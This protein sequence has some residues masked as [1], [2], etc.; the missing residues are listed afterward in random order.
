[1]VMPCK[2]EDGETSTG[3]SS[4]SNPAKSE[5][6][7][8]VVEVVYYLSW[9]GQLGHPH[10]VEVPMSCPPQLLIRDVINMLNR[11]R[12]HG[13]ADMYSWSF[14]RS[15]KNG[16]VWQDLWANDYIYPCNDDDHDYIL[17]GSLLT[18]ASVTPPS[19]DTI[20]PSTSRSRVPSE[21][22]SCTDLGS[23]TPSTAKTNDS[24]WSTFDDHHNIYNIKTSAE[25]WDKGSGDEKNKKVGSVKL[26]TLLNREETGTPAVKSR[27]RASTPGQRRSRERKEVSVSDENGQRA[28][29]ETPSMRKK[30][31]TP[32]LLMILRCGSKRFE[33][34][35]E[36]KSRSY[37]VS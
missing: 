20:S 28:V 36:R 30:T 25:L 2:Y 24:S 32:L 21:I 1:M 15:Y 29:R 8:N 37:P 33:A 31:T 17:K 16:H 6:A 11:R 27:T 12:G 19:F 7:E 5:T 3:S 34:S 18:G 4:V 10:F 22:Q 13:M 9:N 23:I 26:A 14:K 35:P